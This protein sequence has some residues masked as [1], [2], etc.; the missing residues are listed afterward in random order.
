MADSD[1]D[2]KLL[3][4][5]TVTRIMNNALPANANISMD[6]T[7]T[8]QECVSEFVSFI[9]EEASHKSQEEK[10]KTIHG[11][12]LL[13]ALATLGFEDYVDPLR[14]YLDKYREM[15]RV[16]KSIGRLDGSG[17]SG[18][19]GGGDGSDGG[20]GGGGGAGGMHGGMGGG[21]IYQQG[22][23]YD[24]SGQYHH[25]GGGGGDGAGSVGA[26]GGGGGGSTS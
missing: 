12:H 22:P 13:W 7:D 21:M 1:N 15:E 17:G 3:P 26:G 23:I 20:G 6:A 10:W 14:V 16:K 25:M 8:V 5:A 4:I 2:N 19:R 24:G 11:D 18:S 9:T